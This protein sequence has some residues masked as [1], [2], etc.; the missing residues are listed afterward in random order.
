M[1]Q[2]AGERALSRKLGALLKTARREAHDAKQA[3]VAATARAEAAEAALKKALRGQ[4]AAAAGQQV[5]AAAGPAVAGR[6]GVRGAAAA[7]AVVGTGGGGAG[8]AGMGAAGE[9]P[10][11]ER[12]TSASVRRHAEARPL[13]AGDSSAAHKAAAAHKAVLVHKASIPISAA[14][15]PH[16]PLKVKAQQ[17]PPAVGNGR[18]ALPKASKAG[19]AGE[20]RDPRA[21]CGAAGLDDDVD[22]DSV[23]AASLMARSM[24]RSAALLLDFLHAAASLVDPPL[25]SPTTATLGPSGAPSVDL[26]PSG[27]PSVDLGP[28]GAPSVDLKLPASPVSREAATRQLQQ[29]R[30][31]P[32]S[33]RQ[34]HRDAASVAAAAGSAAAATEE[35]DGAS[36]LRAQAGLV[37]RRMGDYVE[38]AHSLVP[39]INCL[40]RCAASLR[41]R[42]LLRSRREEVDDGTLHGIAAEV[43]ALVRAEAARAVDLAGAPMGVAQH[44]LAR[45]QTD[46]DVSSV[47]EISPRIAE[48]A[49]AARLSLSL[50]HRLRSTLDLNEQ[51][52]MAECLAGVER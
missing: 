51:A 4:A 22:S 2:A 48:L 3:A 20:A 32:A 19:E 41:Q 42:R 36:V 12:P 21:V 5:A 37:L 38:L 45:L 44:V 6:A 47:G 26:G 17:V 29:L 10:A 23:E 39:M 15:P 31:G 35:G 40:E 49:G 1:D 24:G 9:A 27:A 52:T 33:N 25:P 14:P 28:S 11:W 18:G 8:G 46:L 34:A 13:A 30:A 7:A 43:D 16:P 50:L